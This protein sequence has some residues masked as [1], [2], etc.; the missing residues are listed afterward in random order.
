VTPGSSGCS[1]IIARFR[2]AETD[3]VSASFR[4]QEGSRE[5]AGQ[6]E[7]LYRALAMLLE[8]E[9]SSL[10]DV[11]RETIY[12]RDVGRDL[13]AVLA[14]RARVLA[15]IG[16]SGVAP[17]P[18]FIQ[19]A[20]V[21]PWA[22]LELS[23]AAT[24]PHDRGSWSVRDVPTIASCPC[25]GCRRSGGRLVRLGPRTTL[26]STN[27]Y[28]TGG[29]VVTQATEM[30]VTAERLLASCGLGFADVIRTWIYLRDIDRDYEALNRARR[31][32]FA[33]SGITLRPASTGVGGPPFPTGHDVTMTLLAVRSTPPIDVRPMATPLLNDAWTYGADFSRGLRVVDADRTTLYVS[34]TASIDEAGHTAHAGDLHAQAERMLDNIETLLARQGASVADVSSGVTYLKHPADATAVRTLFQQRGFD[35]FPCPIVE[36]PLCRPELLCEAEVIAT[37]PLGTAEA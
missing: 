19:Q 13:P 7:S 34:G 21:E 5:A 26:Q 27:L 11:T 2:G 4:P 17:A 29:D 36:A 35:H 24:T 6:A 20:P 32:F 33:R 18:A 16:Q 8:A 30:F 10:Q 12:L 25:E 3:E 14:A 1:T 15:E 22:S 37:L 9:R 23:V 31:T 28:G